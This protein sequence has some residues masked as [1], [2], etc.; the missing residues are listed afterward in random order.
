MMVVTFFLSKNYNRAEADHEKLAN[1]ETRITVLENRKRE[2]E[3]T[4]S[5]FFKEQAILPQKEKEK[6]KAI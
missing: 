6:K 1:H 2:D 5:I 3:R 4:R